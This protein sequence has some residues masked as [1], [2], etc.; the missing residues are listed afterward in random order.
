M[1]VLYKIVGLISADTSGAE[2][3]IRVTPAVFDSK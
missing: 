3:D 2:K 1:S